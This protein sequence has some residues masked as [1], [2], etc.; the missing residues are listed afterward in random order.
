MKKIKI[1]LSTIPTISLPM[2]AISC[3]EKEKSLSFIVNAPYSKQK[4]HTFF[5]DI[6]DQFNQKTKQNLKLELIY[7]SQNNDSI[8]V[9]KKGTSNIA[10]LT[11]PNYISQ[12]HEK[13]NENILPII[14]TKTKAFK[15][16]YNFNDQ[17]SNGQENDKLRQIAKKAQELFE[18]V[19]HALWNDAEYQWDGE[20][21]EFFYQPDNKLVDYYRGIIMIQGNKKQR[22]EIKKAWDQK[23]WNAFRN[24]GILS[25]K[26]GSASKYI[27]Q[28]ELFKKHFNKEGNKF[29]SFAIDRIKNPEKYSTTDNARRDIGRGETKNYNIVFDDFGSFAY[30]NSSKG[31]FSPENANGDVKIEFLTATDPIKYNIIVV[32]KKIFSAEEIKILQEIIIKLWEEKK[33]D[34][35]ASVGFNGYEIITDVKKQVIDPY[36]K[37]FS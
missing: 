14:Q 25:G 7:G 24:F 4:Q 17:Y 20:K 6:L 19:P 3:Y 22:D 29:I 33:D 5:K 27:L 2:L 15:F 26:T 35:G 28:Q 9:I 34:Y 18:K 31:Y 36:K 32:D 11:L 10:V 12:I 37:I 21:Y 23:D 13:G 30:T 1:F 16:D 8:N